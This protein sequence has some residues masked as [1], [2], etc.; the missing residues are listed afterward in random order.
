MASALFFW[1]NLYGLK[2]NIDLIDLNDE[3]HSQGK[4]KHFLAHET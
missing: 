4:P 2:Y 3:T 1:R